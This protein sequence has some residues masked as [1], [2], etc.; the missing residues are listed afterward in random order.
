MFQI[1]DD[2]NLV[3]ISSVKIFATHSI[4]LDSDYKLSSVKREMYQLPDSIEKLKQELKDLK[5]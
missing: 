4:L 2:D 5:S 1:N 3:N